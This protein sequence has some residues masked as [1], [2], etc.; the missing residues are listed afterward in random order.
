MTI[1]EAREKLG[2]L[3]RYGIPAYRL[4]EEVVAKEIARIL[5][6][7]VQAAT[8]EAV[9]DEAALARL[10]QEYD[11]VF[12]AVGA[13]RAKLLPH[14]GEPGDAAG[15]RILDG[16]GFLAEVASG[17][18]PELGRKVGVVGGGSAAMDVARTVKRLGKV[19]AVIAVE[20]RGDMPAL[21]QEVEQALEEGI[22]L[23]EGAMVESVEAGGPML[24]LSCRKV[25]LDPDA[26]EGEIRPLPVEGTEFS[27][28]VDSLIVS[29]GQEVD[30]GGP[31]SA[32]A[33]DRSVI[34]V[35]EDLSTARAGVFAGG[36]AASLVRFVTEAIGDGRRAAHAIASYLGHE[37]SGIEAAAAA[38]PDEA[39][40]ADDVNR[41]YFAPSARTNRRQAPVRERIGDF[42]E[43]IEAL[44]ADEA[45]A[46]ARRC[47]TCG[48][49]VECDNCFI[50]CPDMAVKKDPSRDEHYYVLEQYCKGC[51][52]CVTECPRGAV[53]LR[54]ESR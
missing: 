45:A 20:E 43:V 32:L 24:R 47:L 48:T 21:R 30:T 34:A 2:G 3:L 8:G 31:A 26:P 7:G 46:E 27:L 50:F 51:G 10:E 36:D 15:G 35:G 37:E 12:V 16:L 18:S 39:V 17:G 4:S 41:Y 54:R 25:T 5:D 14:L 22:S 52:L 38:S 53:V 40:K 19:A 42:R 1:F 9:A 44:S 49:C 23:F 13:Q 29:V 11:A 33:E 6:L 28:D